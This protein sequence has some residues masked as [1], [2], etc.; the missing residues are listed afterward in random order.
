MMT[1]LSG[2]SKIK[3]PVSR[4]PE[5]VATDVDVSDDL[6]QE[7]IDRKVAEELGQ[8]SGRAYTPRQSG[9]RV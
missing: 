2:G 1:R 4:E 5:T 6:L 8:A 3:D 9:Q 7:Y